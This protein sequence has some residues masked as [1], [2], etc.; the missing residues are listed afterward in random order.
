MRHSTARALKPFG[1]LGSCATL[2]LCTLSITKSD[3]Q[4]SKNAQKQAGTVA[5]SS[6]GSP[7]FDIPFRP[8]TEIGGWNYVSSEKNNKV[9]GRA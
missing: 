4:N 8:D 7:I 9:F 5:N 3:A 1:A 2:T 6:T